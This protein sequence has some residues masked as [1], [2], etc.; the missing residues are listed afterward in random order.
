MS[1]QN[2]S[3]NLGSVLSKTLSALM[4][5][6]L[7]WGASP[8]AA[9][10][11]DLPD[12][13]VNVSVTVEEYPDTDSV[14]LL[15]DIGFD[16]APDR[17]HT[18][19]EHDAVK[20]LTKDGVDENAVLVRVVDVSESSVEVLLARTI[21][22]DGR[23]LDAAP[24]QLSSLAPGSKV[25]E[26]VK[27]FSIRFPD[28]EVGDVVE[29]HLRTTHK[30]KRG[31]HFWATTYV[32]NPMP[33]LDSTFT[34]TV[35]DGVY[36]R[37]ATPGHPDSKPTEKQISK[38]GVQYQQRSWGIKN[39]N[40]YEFR[41]LAPKTISLLKRI[42]VSSF[43]D[44]N[45]VAEYLEQDWQAHSRVSEGLILR[46]AG[47]MP[48]GGDLRSRVSALVKELNKT[49]KVA[50]F[51][52]DEP[53]FHQPG[54][55]FTEDLVS[56]GDA[57]LLASVTMSAA[58]IQNLP[59]LTFGVNAQS[60]EDELPIPEKVNKIVLEIPRGGQSSLWFDPESP[61]FV[62][63]S[64]PLN[65]SDT[66]AISWDPRFGP[67]ALTLTDL[68]LAS[69]FE[70][71]EELAIE[72]RLESSGRAELTVQF[73]RYGS[74][75]LDSRQAARD[76]S[77]GDR[78][79]RDRALQTFFSNTTRAY[80]PRARLLGRYFE[81]DSE[82]ADPFSLSFTVAVP[83]F[84]QVQDETLLVPLP[85]FLSSNLRAAARDRNRKTPLVFEQPYQQDV[86]IHL[87]FPK[88]SEVTNI[89]DSVRKTSPEAEFV[90]T[91]RAAGNE[92][93]YVGRLTVFDPWTEEEALT[94]S[95]ET[96]DAALRSEDTILKVK[97]APGV[98]EATPTADTEE[99]EDDDS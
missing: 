93:W 30:P 73:D 24:P 52:D 75:A 39:E 4:L 85:R 84:A 13:R 94:R 12:P 18:F 19:D 2:F 21:K 11:A 58:G 77:E 36:F 3:A 47:W 70:N 92:V 31:G 71:R 64:L 63:E 74:T 40:A 98:T 10:M 16:V 54:Q 37:T 88:G 38:N 57:A 26:S 67:G 42:E 5:A 27:R 90:A 81:L 97:L 96:L 95:L 50:S 28:V 22:P 53:K 86:R 20:V 8:A 79:T 65:T 91:G 72:G 46:A 6:G 49:R 55:V 15:D 17:S 9:Q 23:I 29:F 83:G 76:I 66:A 51:L 99:I 33:I 34:V 25:Y 48:S 80:G 69:A 43:H 32:Q 60:L 41:A 56:S 1:K 62:Q 87:I 45:E 44:W 14:L 59:V 68:K 89:P 78:D 61:G 7:L 35:P 82:V